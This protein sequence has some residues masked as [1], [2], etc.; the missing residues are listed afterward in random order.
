MIRIAIDCMG[1]DFGL[2]VTVPAAVNVA[3]KYADLH[4]L[5][6]G[7]ATEVENALQ[8]A[9]PSRPSQF[10]II[11]AEDVINM[12]DPIDV[13]LRHKRKSSMHHAL[14]AVREQRA[15]ACV[16]AGNTGALMAVARFILKTL[17]G[18]DRPAIATSLPNQLGKGTTVLDL[19]ANVDCTPEHLLQFA[20]MGSALV[21]A[22][23]GIEQPKVG[24]L[25]IGHEAIKGNQL[26]KK[27]SEL[28]QATSLNFIG[29]VEGDDIFK[30]TAHVVVCDGFV[31]NVLLKSIEGLA[32]M[33]SSKLKENFLRSLYSKIAALMAK[34]VINQ[35]RKD[36]DNRRYNGAALLGLKGV[37]FKSHGSA[38]ILAFSFAIERARMAVQSQLLHKTRL[39]V[40]AI[41]TSQ[42]EK[43]IV[44]HQEHDKNPPN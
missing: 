11:D 39:G 17:E 23:E 28:L 34:P 24:L 16:S 44:L 9:K 25:N 18:I 7:R 35:F 36:M 33:V 19:G 20:M 37:V 29:N 43:T 3:E 1:G 5:L 22:V 14:H 6:V 38:D 4:F 30:G 21:Q 42:Q 40:E 15:D 32:K 8:L 41:L 2:P 12:D 26:V 13:V 27:T 10:S 31:G